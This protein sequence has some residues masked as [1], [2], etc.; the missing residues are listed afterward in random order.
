MSHQLWPS[1]SQYT[2]KKECR[3]DIHSG[4]EIHEEGHTKSNTGAISG[5]TKWTLV[6]KKFLK[7]TLWNLKSK[8]PTWLETSE[9]AYG[10]KLAL[11]NHKCKNPT[12]LETSKCANFSFYTLES[13][14]KWH[15]E[16]W[17]PRITLPK[18]KTFHCTRWG[19]GWREAAL[20]KFVVQK[21]NLTSNFPNLSTFHF[22]GQGGIERSFQAVLWNL[23]S[24]NPTWLETF[25]SVNFLF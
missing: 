20:L 12:Q 1:E 25:K 8:Y 3:W 11:W 23:K 2:S 4:F 21:S 5:S 15:F 7:K 19:G 13:G 17:S 9:S 18:L 14:G 10:G 22:M 24:K 16:I 6:Q